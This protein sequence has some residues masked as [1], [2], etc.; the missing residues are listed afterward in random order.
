MADAGSGA[1]LPHAQPATGGRQVIEADLNCSEQSRRRATLRRARSAARRFATATSPMRKGQKSKS[2]IL[3]ARGGSG[4][5]S[6]CT[7]DMARRTSR[8]QY[9]A[10]A[11]SSGPEGPG[12]SRRSPRDWHSPLG[13]PRA[14]RVASPRERSLLGCASLS[15]DRRP[16]ENPRVVR[17]L[18]NSIFFRLFHRAKDRRSGFFR[19]PPVLVN[20]ARPVTRKALPLAR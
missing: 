16:F 6:L 13:P 20:P 12:A 17:H 10:L 4:S 8:P 7:R 11:E 1:M 9:D 3:L 2:L 19:P 5:P 18:D 14:L 15:G